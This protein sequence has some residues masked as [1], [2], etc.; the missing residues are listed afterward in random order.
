M[1]KPNDGQVQQVGDGQNGAR[2]SARSTIARCAVSADRPARPYEVRSERVPGLLL[3]VQ[4]SGKRT[5]YVQVARGKRVRLGPAGVLTL[6]QAEARARAVLLDPAAAT[7]VKAAGTTLGEYLDDTYGPWV[8]ARRKD[9]SGTLAR[10][11]AAWVKLLDRRLADITSTMVDNIRT[12]RLAAGRAPATVNRDVAALSSVLT[13]WVKNTDGAVHPL[14]ELESIDEPDDKRVRYLTPDE[15]RRL[16]QALAERD[17]A[18]KEA[19]ERYNVWCRQRGKPGLPPITDFC[20]HV[21]PMVLL[22]L[23]TGLRQ[24]E[25][26][27]LTWEAIN[28]EKRQ[29]TVLAATSKG[30]KTRVVPLNDEALGVLLSI[31]PPLAAG[32]VFRSPKTKGQFDNVKKAWDAVTKAAG[33]ADLR[34]HDL[35]HDFASQLVMRGVSLYTVQELLGHGSSVMTQRYAHLQPDHL[36]DAVSVLVAR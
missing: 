3:R 31:K 18:G 26:F 23:N 12:E 20:D 11:R 19:R 30:N 22:S 21:T 2:S 32:L 4:P 7:K 33:I 1:A 17:Q 15:N 34:W 24:G 14:H 36:A 10:I 5:F 9:A 13:L 16:R 8:Q 29:I 6:Q 28:L 27:G 25:L 35:R